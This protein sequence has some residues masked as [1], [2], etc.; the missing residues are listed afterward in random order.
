[1][2][3]TL[4][5]EFIEKESISQDVIALQIGDSQQ[6]VSDFLKKDGKP[7]EKTRRKYLEKLEGFREYYDTSK[8]QIKSQVKNPDILVR[9]LSEEHI[10]II[11]NAFLFHEEE[12]KQIITVKKMIS[13]ERLEAQNTILREIKGLK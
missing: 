8:S 3:K 7:Q 2:F 11:N 4:L 5:R 12:V 13:A 10:Q 1:M 6:A 9:T